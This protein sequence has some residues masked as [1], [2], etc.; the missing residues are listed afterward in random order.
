MAITHDIT[1]RQ[2]SADAVLALLNGGT[3]NPQ[4]SLI[5]RTA[6]LAEVANLPLSNP[7]AGATDGTGVATF[8]AI[9][10]DTTTIA[11]TVSNFILVD[12]DVNTIISGT[13]SLIGGGGDIELTSL[14][15]ANNETISMNSLTYTA[16]V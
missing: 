13:V 1:A 2:A 10:D 15:Y 16:Q 6:A 11:G 8:N 9:T 4:G 14:T 7:A 3:T 5:F 12:R